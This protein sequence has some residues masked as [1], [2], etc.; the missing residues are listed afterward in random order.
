MDMSI[1]C[2]EDIL[3]QIKNNGLHLQ[4][5]LKIRLIS[6]LVAFGGYIALFLLLQ[7]YALLFGLMFWTLVQVRGIFYA[8]EMIVYPNG[9]ETKRFGIRRFTHWRDIASVRVGDY[10]SQIQPKDIH[11]LIKYFFYSYLMIMVWR[12]NYKEAMEVVR[13]NVE[14]AQEDSP[15]RVYE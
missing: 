13:N 10:V 4:A 7:D 2:S 8:P 15:Q 6:S 12:S 9:I 5:P 11:P 14:Q 3:M 1:Y